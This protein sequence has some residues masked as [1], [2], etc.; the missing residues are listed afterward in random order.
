MSKTPAKHG[1]TLAANY[2]FRLLAQLPRI[3]LALN[4]ASLGEMAEK[5]VEFYAR[6]LTNRMRDTGLMFQC[7]AAPEEGRW[8]KTAATDTFAKH[9]AFT[10]AVEWTGFIQFDGTT[11]VHSNCAPDAMM[12][13]AEG[14]IP[15]I[16]KEET[17]VPDPPVIEEPPPPELPPEPVE[18]PPPVVTPR[19]LW[20]KFFP[21]HCTGSQFIVRKLLLMRVNY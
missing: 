19:N 14:R 20:E 7:N 16:R 11:Y 21:N 3:D 1:V 17:I 18:C 9:F 8:I 5:Q 12:I 4:F 15:L 10:E 6:E 13:P 2:A